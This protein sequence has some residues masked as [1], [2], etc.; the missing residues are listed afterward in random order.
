MNTLRIVIPAC[1]EA[2]RIERTLHD[3]C[4][5]FSDIATVL[6]VANG[7]V[8]GTA[9]VVSKLRATYPNLQFMEISAA[10]GK[11]GA[12]RA[13]LAVGPEPYVGYVDADGS[14]EAKEFRRLFEEL[15]RRGIDGIIGSRWLPGSVLTPPQPLKRRIASRVF[16]A[17]VRMMMGLR[18][19]DT[20]CGAKVFRRGAVTEVLHEL[21]ISDFAFDIDLL[22]EMRRNHRVVAEVPTRWS[23]VAQGSNVR[24]LSSS[25]KMLMALMRLRFRR[26][27]LARLP[28]FDYFARASVMPVQRELSVLVLSDHTARGPEADF[29]RNFANE[30]IAHGHRVDWLGE[31]EAKLPGIPHLL[32]RFYN[33]WLV[34]V[35]YAAQSNRRYNAIVELASPEPFIFPALSAKR[36]FVVV[37]K[38]L[39]AP[40]KAFY[41]RAYK[42]AE[43]LSGLDARSLIATLEFD[44]VYRAA[45][46]F[47][48]ERWAVRY[49]EKS[50]EVVE[51]QLL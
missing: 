49:V 20:Q 7:C 37:P 12:V 1:N 32:R 42:S 11:G 8:D 5:E 40:F 51:L 14:T 47:K 2:E 9:R 41:R 38:A 18:F 21:E 19:S 23:D 50:T 28:F 27:A 30:L 44:H 33:R 36:T 3:Y 34:F 29:L 35:W 26:S 10:I 45:F 39:G 13:G 15:V 31:S 48:D 22:T 24:I 43:F 25:R 46:V 17:V 6:V 4:R 16:N